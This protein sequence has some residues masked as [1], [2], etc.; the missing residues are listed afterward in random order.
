MSRRERGPRGFALLAVLSIV[1]LL[2]VIVVFAIQLS[3][4]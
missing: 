4:Q 3:G 2:T 1:V